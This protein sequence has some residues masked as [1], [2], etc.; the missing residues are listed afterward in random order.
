M[1]KVV[2]L[3]LI[4]SNKY[5]IIVIIPNNELSDPEAKQMITHPKL[6]NNK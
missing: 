4:A 5:S 2:S 1:N 3:I 6:L